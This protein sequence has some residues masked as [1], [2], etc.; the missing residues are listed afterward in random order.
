M[1]AELG[2]DIAREEAAFFSDEEFAAALL[3][4]T[5]AALRETFGDSQPM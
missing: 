3:G 1:L 4:T 2:L 5:P